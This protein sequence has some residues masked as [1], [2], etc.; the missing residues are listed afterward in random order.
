MIMDDDIRMVGRRICLL[1]VKD[2]AYTL[3]GYTL[4]V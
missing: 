1:R 4:S 2:Q 3:R